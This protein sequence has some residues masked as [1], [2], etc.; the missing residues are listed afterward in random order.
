MHSPRW[1]VITRAKQRNKGKA[2]ARRVMEMVRR[3]A[4][5]MGRRMISPTKMPMGVGQI[6][7]VSTGQGPISAKFVMGWGIGQKIAWV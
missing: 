7:M 1:G 2:R 5:V 3:V 6:R 4:R